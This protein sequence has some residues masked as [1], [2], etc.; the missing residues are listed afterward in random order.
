MTERSIKNLAR[1]Y[2]SLAIFCKTLNADFVH[3]NV[4]IDVHF[5][6]TLK[7]SLPTILLFAPGV[8]LVN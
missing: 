7:Y 1:G 2:H 5:T 6:N 8:L 4:P 3:T